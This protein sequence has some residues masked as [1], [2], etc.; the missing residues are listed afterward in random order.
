MDNYAE[1]IAVT[2]YSG[3]RYAALP[4]VF[5]DILRPSISSYITIA[6]KALAGWILLCAVRGVQEADANLIDWAR[7]RELKKGAGPQ[8]QALRALAFPHMPLDSFSEEIGGYIAGLHEALAV[9]IIAAEKTGYASG[10][11]LLA[12]AKDT[13]DYKDDSVG[14]LFARAVWFSPRLSS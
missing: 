1:K 13:L 2:H 4:P 5:F 10:W 3:K 6:E 9:C 8:Q 7:R 12:W 11:S 14:A